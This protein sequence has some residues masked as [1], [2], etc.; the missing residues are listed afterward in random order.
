VRIKDD[1]VNRVRAWR[2]FNVWGSLFVGPHAKTDVYTTARIC[3]SIFFVIKLN[4]GS[5]GC[6]SLCHWAR[7]VSVP[8]RLT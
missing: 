4:P 7:V 3:A 6:N 2:S 1:G 8:R 5:L